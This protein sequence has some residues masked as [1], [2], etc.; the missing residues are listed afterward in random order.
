VLSDPQKRSQYDQF[1]A[2]FQQQAQAGNGYSGFE[3]SPDFSSFSEAF[4]FGRGQRGSASGFEDIFEGIFGG[5]ATGRA[6]RGRRS[7]RGVDIGVDVEI[8]LAEAY[9]GTE[10]EINLRKAVVCSACGGRGFEPGVKTKSCPTCQG[11]GQIE[12]RRGGGFFTFSQIKSCPDCRGEGKKPDKFCA[13]CGGEGRV[14]EQKS[15]KIKI[16]AGIQGEAAPHGG[17]A[18]D[19]Y[20]TVHV[21][22]DPRFRREGDDLFYELSITFFQAV[23]GDKIEVPTLSGWVN[24]KIPEGV[25]P[26]TVIRLE[27]K[28]LPRLARRGFGDMMVKIK[29]AMPK[30]LSRR[31]REL[32]TELKKETN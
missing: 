30:R 23:L 17:S 29:L 26:G 21:S 31:A 9:R 27:G 12:E 20:V 13:R 8:S 4:N 6:G 18:G 24:L 10:R 22:S 25:E 11:H 19:L 14:K 28:G 2:T 32:L 5:R 15:L 1:G 3:G 16:P 7:S